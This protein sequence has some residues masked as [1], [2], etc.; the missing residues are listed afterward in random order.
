MTKTVETPQRTPA[1]T[2]ERASRVVVVSLMKSGTHLIQELMVALGYGMYGQSRIT[3]DIRPTLDVDT[4]RTLVETVHG[5]TAAERLAAS[6]LAP[7]GP[8][9]L[10]AAASQAWE[11][12]GW[13][14]QLR[15]GLPLANR[16]GG[17]L[18]DADLVQR[19]VAA[20]R[21]AT[22]A[23]TPPNVC[24]ILPEFDI[25]RIDGGF[26]REW[27]DTGE[28]R[29][30]LNY[31]DPRDMV[32]SMVNFLSG[33]TAGGIGNFSEF[34]A[35]HRILLAMPTMQERLTYALTDPAFPGFDDLRGALWLLHHPDVHTVSFEQL[36]GERGGGTAAAQRRAVEDLARFVG[37]RPGAGVERALYRTDSFS[38]YSG[39]IGAWREVFTAE[40]ER[41]FNDRCASILV[42]YGYS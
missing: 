24:W 14:W 28:P 37:A 34:R 26:L 33:N 7:A 1:G 36:V 22:F 20:T 8:D 16:Y 35:F 6:G 17:A 21:D 4:Q 31:R 3:P 2:S 5:R 39:R 13:A 29:I 15:F 12:L 32:V 41:L 40:H 18:V 10:A 25:H 11:A 9:S 27:A 38:F 30:V 42:A 23:E 19:A